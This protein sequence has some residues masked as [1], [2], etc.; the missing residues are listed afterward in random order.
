M[1]RRTKIVATLGPATDDPAVL[2]EVIRR[3]ADVVRVNFSHGEPEAHRRRVEGV[4]RA[5]ARVGKHVAV[6]GDLQGPKIRIEGFADG[7]VLLDEGAR[8]A[9]DPAID[10][11]EGTARGV[12]ITYHQLAADVHAGDALILG[13]G[14]IELAVESVQ[15]DRVECR[16]TVGGELSDH[17]GIN[18]RG[19][20]LSAK[21]LTDKDREDVRLA[22][23]L[24]RMISSSRGIASLRSIFETMQASLPAA[25]SRLRAS[26]TSAAWRTNETAR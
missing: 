3:G 10:P 23:S 25:R 2:E 9:L 17:K 15:G 4:R 1:L 18:R 11:T 24:A 16:V 8:F 21:A 7:R 13:D 12:G 5:A 14:Q 22:A 6:L 26:S 20:G 19:G